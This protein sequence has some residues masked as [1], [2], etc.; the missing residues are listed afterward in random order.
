MNLIND[1]NKKYLLNLV[2]QTI[3]TKLAQKALPDIDWGVRRPRR[4][5]I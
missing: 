2:I 5:S 3:E 4:V 1:E